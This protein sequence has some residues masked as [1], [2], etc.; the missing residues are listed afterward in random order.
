MTP[1]RHRWSQPIRTEHRSVR[2]CVKCQMRKISHHQGDEHWVEFVGTD[3][4]I[5]EQPHHGRVVTPERQ[6]ASVTA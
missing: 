2:T 5:I 1:S 3:G 4:R 6:P